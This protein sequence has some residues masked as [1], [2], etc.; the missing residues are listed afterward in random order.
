MLLLVDGG[1]VIK[2][3]TL[4]SFGV[5]SGINTQQIMTNCE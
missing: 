2:E 3:A 5:S 1:C 4:S